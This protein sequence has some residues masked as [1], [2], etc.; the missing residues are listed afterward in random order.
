M[1]F[2]FFLLRIEIIVI[3]VA[4]VVVVGVEYIIVEFIQCFVER[5]TILVVCRSVCCCRMVFVAENSLANKKD[6]ND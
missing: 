6:K 2:F 3:S 4:V 5:S 1:Y